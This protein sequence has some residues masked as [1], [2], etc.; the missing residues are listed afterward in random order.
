MNPRPQTAKHFIMN[1][2]TEKKGEK[3][4]CSNPNS[5]RV[6]QIDK[7]TW[8]LFYQG[9]KESL[10][11]GKSLTFT[12]MV[13]GMRDYLKANKIKFSQSVDWY[14]V[15]VKNDLD[16]RKMIKVYTEKGR[17]LHSWAEKTK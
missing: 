4:N 14:T 1:K 15:T 6:M 5:G 16:V 13:E 8:E 7:D 9:I 17:K 11:G 3:V 2:T 10:K 12:E